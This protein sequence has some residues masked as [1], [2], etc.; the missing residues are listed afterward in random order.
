MASASFSRFQTALTDAQILRSFA[1]QASSVT[2]VQTQIDQACLKASVANGVGC[3]EGYIEGVLQEFVAKTRVQAQSKA[4]T[5]IVQF[6]IMV[7]KHTDGLNTPNWEKTRELISHITGIDP[8]MSWIWI[9]KFANQQLTKDFFDGVMNV[10]HAFAHG[11][12]IPNDV[13]GLITSGVLD[14][15]YVDE[16]LECLKFFAAATD[17]LLEH[18][19]MHRHGCR[20]GWR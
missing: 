11:F 2:A 5:L 18:E 15:A 16:A 10:R 4:W 19:L 8:Y 17:N 3:W 6:E 12:P 7:K 14:V 9:P 13:P 1:G 20:T